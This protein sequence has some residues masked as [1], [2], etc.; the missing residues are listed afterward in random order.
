MEWV[1]E[2]DRNSGVRE[3]DVATGSKES[4]D[5]R[6]HR[7]ASYLISH[8][9]TCHCTTNHT[10]YMSH[11]FISVTLSEN[12]CGSTQWCGSSQ[13]VGNILSHHVP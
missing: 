2:V 1:M 6:L 13:P 7:P 4:E 10:L 3:R 11:V 8:I 9:I 5:A 12:P